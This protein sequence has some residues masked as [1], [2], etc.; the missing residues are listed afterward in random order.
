MGVA[1]DFERCIAAGGVAVFAADTVYGLAC[2][3]A[4]PAAVARMYALKG[5][6]PEKRSAT[7]H[8]TAATLPR[9]PPRTA[10]VIAR[11]TPGPLTFVVGE[12]GLRL[13][14]VPLL[15]GVRTPVLQ[16]SANHAG[17]PDARRLEDVPADIRAAADL[18]VDGGEL[19]GTPSTVVDLT[20]YED[21]GTWVVLREGAVPR[22][23]LE[24]ALR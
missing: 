24:A 10:A 20:G 17:G 23:A 16:T 2:A 1:R 19:P 13:P 21:A 4:D 8:F 18:V 12:L 5:R 11:L 14:D 15:R 9:L 22:A 3:P 7:M 6:A